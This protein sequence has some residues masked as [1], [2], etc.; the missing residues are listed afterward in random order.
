MME[1]FMILHIVNHYIPYNQIKAKKPQ[2]I[3]ISDFKQKMTQ[4]WPKRTIFEIS[5]KM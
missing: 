5:Q 4:I 2:A 1:Y 3:Y